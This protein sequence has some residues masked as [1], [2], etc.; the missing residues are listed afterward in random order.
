MKIWTLELHQKELCSSSLPPLTTFLWWQC[1]HYRGGWNDGRLVC[2]ASSALSAGP[3]A[4]GARRTLP[5]P[6]GAADVMRLLSDE[7]RKLSRHRRASTVLKAKRKIVGRT[8]DRTPAI[9]HS[10]QDFR[11]AQ[12]ANRPCQVRLQRCSSSRSPSHSAASP[13]TP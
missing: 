12:P 11:T 2:L 4:V 1:R 8:S 5:W 7:A 3:G 10:R 9:C 6:S 13:C